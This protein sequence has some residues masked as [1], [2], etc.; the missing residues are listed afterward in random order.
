MNKE[1]QRETIRLY[2]LNN[3]D[4]IKEINRLYRL[5]NQERIKQY[6]LN[7][8]ERIKEV[9]KKYLLN[10]KDH[11]K[12][13]KKKYYL[14]KLDKMLSYSKKYYLDNKEKK[15]KFG[16][17][18]RLKN[19]D[20]QKIQRLKNPSLAIFYC[21][22]RNAAKLKATPRF[23]NLEKIKE[24]YKNCPKGYTV[25]HIVPLQGKVVCGLHVEWNLQYL[26][27]SENSSKSNKLINDYL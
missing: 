4:K 15:I 14:K 18:W 9:T 6:R 21:A 8:K 22:K 10:N 23:A 11:I 16:K 7:N 2:R 1:K 3:K 25:D 12:K 5:S 24:I 19:K 27:P 17:L 13:V 20:Y 26:T